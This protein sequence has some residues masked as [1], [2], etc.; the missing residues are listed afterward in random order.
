M[1]LIKAIKGV[2]KFYKENKNEIQESLEISKKADKKISIDNSLAAFRIVS[3]KLKVDMFIINMI[4]SGVF[5]IFYGYMI[6]LR[7]AEIV[8]I[9]F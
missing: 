2:S 4:S 3:N 1:G 7:R 8:Q 5:L 6:Y 9:I